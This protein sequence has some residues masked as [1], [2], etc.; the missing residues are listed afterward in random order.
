LRSTP[1]L[2]GNPVPRVVDQ[3]GAMSEGFGVPSCHAIEHIAHELDAAL[4]KK[5]FAELADR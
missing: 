2:L 5:R 4:R 1:P 3:A